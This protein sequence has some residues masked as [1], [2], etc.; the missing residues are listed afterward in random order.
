MYLPQVRQCQL[1][2]DDGNVLHRVD[3]AVHVDDV[4]ILEAAHHLSCGVDMSLRRKLELT[5]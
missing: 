4:I 2:V 1:E 3:A 5:H